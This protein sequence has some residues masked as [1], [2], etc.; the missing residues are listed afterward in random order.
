[1]INNIEQPSNLKAGGV[2]KYQHTRNGI[3]I[4]E[5]EDPNI[6]PDEGIMKIIGSSLAG[7]SAI[8]TW[9]IGLYKNNYTPIAAN[10]MS[11]FP[12]AGVAN[13]VT[14]EY[15]E[16]AR[17][18]WTYGVPAAN[19]VTNAASPA[20]FTFT[21]ASTVVFGAFM[22]S[23]SVKGG[24]T[25]TLLAATKFPASRTLLTTDSLTVTYT[26]SASST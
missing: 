18:P 21:P 4:D 8:S 11:T 1:M 9:Y 10:V 24:T 25:G 2:F 5:W 7:Q 16:V 12:G 20:V 15:S 23:S 3:I 13:E 22:S 6:I 19:S 26:I 17:Q 14:T